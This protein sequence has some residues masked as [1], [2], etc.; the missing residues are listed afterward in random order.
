MI[1]GSPTPERA[2]LETFTGR[3]VSFRYLS[4]LHRLPADALDGLDV[5][6]MTLAVAD[7]NDAAWREVFAMG[8]S[9]LVLLLGRD[10][11]YLVD[12]TNMQAYEATV[13]GRYRD[14]GV[15]VPRT[16]PL[17]V[18][19]LPAL[20]LVA[21]GT[22]PSGEQVQIRATEIFA[23]SAGYVLV[24]QAAPDRRAELM[25]A[26]GSIL[27][28]IAIQPKRPT[29]TW[30]TLASATDDIRLS[31]PPGW[32]RP[33]TLPRG[34]KVAASLP[35][36]AEGTTAARVQVATVRLRRPVPTSVYVDAVA[37][38]MKRYLVGR[39]PFRMDGRAGQMVRFEDKDAGGVFYLLVDGRTGFA[40]RF[41]IPLGNQSFALLRPT[42]D[43]IAASLQ[44][45]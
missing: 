30:T 43:A 21:D 28:S 25:A 24:C 44:L 41:D 14:A 4:T 8:E 17:S 34:S 31:V 12:D 9:D 23:G 18:D 2:T 11:S 39:R 26:C 22:T 13:V 10:P 36:S 20:S 29:S 33:E 3:G 27:R 1:Q 32:Q 5:G 42:M 38:K 15:E 40:V 7:A 6:E 16:K 35:A 37:D 45:R 19:R